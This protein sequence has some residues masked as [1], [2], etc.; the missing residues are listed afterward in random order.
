MAKSKKLL[1]QFQRNNHNETIAREKLVKSLYLTN[2]LDLAKI[3]GSKFLKENP[4]DEIIL[5]YMCRIS[6]DSDNLE[7]EKHYL[8]QLININPDKASLK[9]IMRL[10]KVNSILEKQKR[11]EEEKN[12]PINFTE[13]DLKAWIDHLEHNFKY[14]NISL[15]DIDK[16]IEE[17]KTYPNY[18]KSLI[19]LLDIKAVITEDYQEELDD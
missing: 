10:D 19:S 3:T 9:N 13:E 12:M 15:A 2:N 6:R 5:W 4:N 14:G 17:A 18:I 8:E 16:K 1:N 11:R 7:D